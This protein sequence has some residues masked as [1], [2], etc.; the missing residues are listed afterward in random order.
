[1]ATVSNEQI[2]KLR[3]EKLNMPHP[4]PPEI[5]ALTVVELELQLLPEEPKL[6]PLILQWFLQVYRYKTVS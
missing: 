5:T 6:C 1:M 2:W 4:L 3:S